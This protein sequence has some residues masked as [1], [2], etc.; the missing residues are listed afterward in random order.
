MTLAF[1]GDMHFDLHLAALFD[2][3]QGALGPVTRT[4]ADADL[5]MVNLES[6]ITDRGTPEAKE[7]E[8]PGQ[9]FH[10]RTAPAALDVL[11]AAG[12]TW[13][14]WPTTTAPTTER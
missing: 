9:R 4:L 6:A 1:A 14:R 3:P 2:Q 12:S 10:F 8:E 11:A 7:L 13:S 5:T